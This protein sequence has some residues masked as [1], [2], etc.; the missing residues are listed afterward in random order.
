MNK[1]YKILIRQATVSF[2]GKGSRYY[3]DGV[4]QLNL[5]GDRASMHSIHGKGFLDGFAEHGVDIMKD[6][7]INLIEGYMAPAIARAVKF[8]L[9]HNKGLK[10]IV[11]PLRLVLIDLTDTEPTDLHWVEVHLE[12]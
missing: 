8:H 3:R 5:Y 7:G 2:Y 1:P 9:R 4:A 12:I 6:L 10:V 11:N